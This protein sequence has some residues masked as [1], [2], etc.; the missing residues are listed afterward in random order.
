MRRYLLVLAVCIFAVPAFSQ[1]VTTCGTERWPIKTGCDAQSGDV[2]VDNPVDT[3]IADLRK[4]P[5]PPGLHH[6][7]TRVP[8]VEDKVFVIEATLTLFKSESDE[9]FHLVLSDHGKTMIAE[10]PNPSCVSDDSP[11]HGAIH[12]IRPC[13]A[14]HF[15]NV[16]RKKNVNVRVRVTGV[17]FFDFIHG[18]TG[19]APNGI[20]LHPILGITFLDDADGTECGQAAQ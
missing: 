9:D 16:K 1:C 18:Q 11:F 8:D 5:A 3:T 13:F 2:D 10:I 19:V 12:D 15:G 4:L 20:E 17:G 7:N 14:D 6:L